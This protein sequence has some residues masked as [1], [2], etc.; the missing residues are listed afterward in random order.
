M[1]SLTE[2]YQQLLNNIVNL[3]PTDLDLALV[4]VKGQNINLSDLVNY[5]IH[6]RV[7][8]PGLIRIFGVDDWLTYYKYYKSDKLMSVS[9]KVSN[10]EIYNDLIKILTEKLKQLDDKQ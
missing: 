1:D 10:E 6:C 4:L 5:M 9:V 3:M 7:K 2:D 8:I